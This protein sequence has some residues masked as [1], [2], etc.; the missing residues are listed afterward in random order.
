MKRIG[1][2]HSK[3]YSYENI[4]LAFRNAKKGKRSYSEVKKI[5]ANTKLYLGQIHEMLKNETF[6]NSPYEVFEKQSGNKVREIFKLPFF[7][8]RIIHHCIVQVCQPIWMN[9]F[10][11]DTFSTIPGRGIH[12]GV[13][14]MKE[15]MIHKPK[16]CLKIDVRKYYPSIDHEVLKQIIKKKIK[17][18]KTLNLM[19]EII[20]SAPGVPIGNYLSQWFG[21]VYLSYLDHFVKEKLGVKN[22]FRYCDDMV[23][24]HDSKAFLW[25]CLDQIRTELSILKLD[26][27]YNY[28]VFPVNIR[29]IDF[30]GY[31]FFHTHTLVR[32]NIVKNFKARIN[33]TA[34]KQ[35]FS[36][37]WGWL[38]HAN[39]YNLTKKYF[40]MHSFSDFAQVSFA[41]E[42]EKKRME[43]II[44][45]EIYISDFRVKDSKHNTGD[46]L[47]MQFKVEGD[48]KKYVC[49]TGSNVLIKQ[50][51]DYKDQ[52]P[53]KTKIKA[54]QNKGKRYYSFT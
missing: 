31:R 1:N 54:F 21:N 20:D 19:S 45:T 22:Y 43:D 26:V 48:D 42:G 13:Q 25:D 17:C 29:G 50:C 14:R 52:L 38:K 9:L 15:A 34:T 49:F 8:D 5:E 24:L 33:K 47:S 7:P 4:E 28:Q 3:I 44:N 53:F 16:Y 30:L 27:K 6:K 35:A 11:Y 46:Y 39:S 18:E 36:A 23:L 40:D 37:Y 32:K 41:L 10:I 51:Q 2:L 12:A